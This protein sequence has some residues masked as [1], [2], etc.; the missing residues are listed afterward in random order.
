M[1]NKKTCDVCENS[2]AYLHPSGKWLCTIHF[3]KATIKALGF[4]AFIGTFIYLAINY[5]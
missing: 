2:P 5:L 4:L 3:R 1:S